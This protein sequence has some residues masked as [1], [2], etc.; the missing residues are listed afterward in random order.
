MTSLATYL[1]YNATS[2]IRTSVRKAI[3]RSMDY[4]GNPSSMH[5]FGRTTRNL[6]EE[7]RKNVA[8]LLGCQP[9]CVIFTSGGTEA[10]AL[11]INGWGNKRFLTSSIEHASVL[12]VKYGKRIAVKQ[13]GVIDLLELDRLLS[14]S[15]EPTLVTVMLAN[16]ETGVIQPIID[17]VRLAK[18]HGAIVHC[19]A[20]Q[21]VGKIKINLCELGVDSLA[22]SAHKIGGPA[23]VGALLL[24]NPNAKFLPT[25]LGGDQEWTRRAGTENIIGIIGFGAAAN[26]VN[27]EIGEVE[28]L[29]GLRD[30]IE[31]IFCE[32]VPRLVIF[33]KLTARLPNTSCFAVPDVMAQT[34]LIGLD[35]ANIA[36]SS[37]SA[38]SSGN[39]APSHVLVAMGADF[40]ASS[41]IRVSFGWASTEHDVARFIDVFLSLIN[42]FDLVSKRKLASA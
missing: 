30:R 18:A 8:V 27:G 40:L 41:A 10:N 38:C 25:L 20:I 22:V 19:D 31:Q 32:K 26:E 34:L 39:V 24:T 5:S 42:R 29:A 16:N 36:V 12:K 9:E 33:G 37:G 28:R 6:I 13:S 1:D 4:F 21:A 17:V 3:M 35:L 2:P 14:E 15:N 11:A 23:G 7:A